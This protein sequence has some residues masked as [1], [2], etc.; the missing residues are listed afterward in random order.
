[1][2]IILK[3][4]SRST[5]SLRNTD[6]IWVGARPSSCSRFCLVP[7]LV[8]SEPGSEIQS[9]SGLLGLFCLQLTLAYPEQ[10]QLWPRQKHCF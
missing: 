2:S 1:M 6:G 5:S 9:C 8:L 7:L 10:H 3:P 4:R